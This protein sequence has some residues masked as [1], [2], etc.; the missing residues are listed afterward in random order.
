MLFPG[1]VG[2]EDG[3]LRNITILLATVLSA[4]AQTQ[5]DLRTQSKNGAVTVENGGVAVGGRA[6]HNF[7][8]GEGLVNAM[9]DTGTRIN[10]QQNVDSAVIQTRAG[11]QSGVTLLCASS[12]ASGSAYACSMNPTLGAHT[13]GMVLFW[14]PDVDGAGGAVTLD[15]DTLG[16]KAVKLADGIADPAVTDIRSG[17]LY[18]FGMTAPVFV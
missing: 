18:P 16:P 13:Q 8:P 10:I 12:S 11:A 7:I 14:K 3:M 6:V 9:T 15:V 5:V 17:R 4:G 1:S 2:V